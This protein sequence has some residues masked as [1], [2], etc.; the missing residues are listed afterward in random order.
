MQTTQ[1]P[2]VSAVASIAIEKAI[3]AAIDAGLPPPDEAA[4][5][6]IA[7]E[8]NRQAV[9]G[10]DYQVDRKTGQPVQ[11]GIGAWP[12]NVTLNHLT[13]IRRYEGQASYERILKKLW[14]EAPE[15]AKRIGAA[16]PDRVA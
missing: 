3:N 2:Y 10:F 13:S 11:Q 4:Q 16:E 1:T 12:H 14:K 8:A 7:D 6:K 9:F 5:K 15:V